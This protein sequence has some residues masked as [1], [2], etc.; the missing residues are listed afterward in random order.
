MPTIQEL[1]AHLYAE[2]PAG[3]IIDEEAV[4]ACALAAVRFYAGYADLEADQAEERR[5]V[6]ENIRP[7]TELTAGEWSVIRPLFM[8]YAERETAYQLEASRAMGV[9]VFGR[10]VSEISNEILQVENEIPLKAFV[11]NII[12]I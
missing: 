6:L 8:L 4:T 3:V 7:E 10:S 1:A 9:D 11:H 5:T 12:E 2:R